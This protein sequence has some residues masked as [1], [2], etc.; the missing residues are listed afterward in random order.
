MTYSQA[1]QDDFVVEMLRGKK[2][3]TYVEIGSNHSQHNNNTYLLEKEYGWKG[4]SFEIDKG[5]Q[6]EFNANRINRCILADATT[7]DYKTLFEALELPHQIDYLQ[8]DIDPAYQSLRA[9][10]ALPLHDYR[11]S[12][13]TFEH[14]LYA[15]NQEVK[16]AQ[17]EIL[18]SLGY[19]LARENVTDGKP[20]KPFEDWWIDPFFAGDSKSLR[21]P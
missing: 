16:D 5:F 13:I 17:K 10:Q 3:G 9:L 18:F 21:N 11:F 20:E 4:I 15:G 6:E 8:V 12:V 1:G 19:Q 7:Y 2:R 14:D